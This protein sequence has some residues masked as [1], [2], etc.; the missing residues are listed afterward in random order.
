MPTGWTDSVIA[1]IWQCD[2]CHLQCDCWQPGQH[3]VL[4]P[5]PLARFRFHRQET[6]ILKVDECC[7]VLLWTQVCE[8]CLRGRGEHSNM[9]KTAPSWAPLV[10]D[11]PRG[12]QWG[13]QHSLFCYGHSSWV[14]FISVYREVWNLFKG[15]IY[16]F[17]CLLLLFICLLSY[18]CLFLSLCLFLCL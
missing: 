15:I 1:V 12:W 18:D 17:V 3:A 2:C 14:S 4:S 11:T 13:Q 9:P 6:Q 8:V 7:V 16:L 5:R 10:W